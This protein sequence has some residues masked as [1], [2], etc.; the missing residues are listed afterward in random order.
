MFYGEAAM[1]GCMLPPWAIFH[2]TSVRSTGRAGGLLIGRP[3]SCCGAVWGV[4]ELI[5]M[6]KPN[7]ATTSGKEL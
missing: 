7:V 1:A 6:M 2:T 5:V 4:N 3:V